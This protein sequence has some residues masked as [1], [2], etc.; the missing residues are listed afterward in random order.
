MN[1]MMIPKSKSG[2]SEGLTK[3]GYQKTA[4]LKLQR[5]KYNE[6]IAICENYVLQNFRTLRYIPEYDG[7]THFIVTTRSFL[8][9]NVFIVRS[10][11]STW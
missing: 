10:R 2:R 9:G 6:Y 3:V 1:S 11:A 5:T 8:L 4:R 7:S